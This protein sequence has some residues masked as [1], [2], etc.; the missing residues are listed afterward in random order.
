MEVDAKSWAILA[1][2]QDNARQSLTELAQ[3]VGLSVPAVSERVKRLEEA[4]GIRGYHAVVAPLKAGDALSALVGM[5]AVSIAVVMTCTCRFAAITAR[6]ADAVDT[7]ICR[8][9]S[10]CD[11]RAI[12]SRGSRSPMAL[13]AR[14]W[15]A[16]MSWQSAAP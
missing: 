10:A 3:A 7:A 8:R 16:T 1:A 12:A 13:I 2:L 5:K 9:V 6:Y 15:T 14:R 11:S 4:G